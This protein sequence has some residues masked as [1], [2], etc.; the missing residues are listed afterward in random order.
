MTDRLPRV[1]LVGPHD[2]FRALLDRLES[3]GGYQIEAAPTLPAAAQRL[4]P[5]PEV[6]LL[7]V[8]QERP[9]AEEALAWL[10]KLRGRT[11]ALVVSPAA[12]MSLYLAAMTHGA[13]DYFTSYT[14]PDEIRRG[15]DN[16]LRWRAR[17]NAA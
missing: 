2:A 4:D 13:F 5:A 10:E 14:P 16:A 1:L 15:L 11:L 12:D 3:L 6:V 9:Q 17:Q 7:H 8:S